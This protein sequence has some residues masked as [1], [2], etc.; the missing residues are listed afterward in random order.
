MLIHLVQCDVCR[1]IAPMTSAQL[2]PHRA[3]VQVVPMRWATDHDQREEGRD[4]H[5]CSRRCEDTGI[6]R[7]LAGE[8]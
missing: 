1:A 6:T 3:E 7:W 5:F 2:E 4:R 8:T